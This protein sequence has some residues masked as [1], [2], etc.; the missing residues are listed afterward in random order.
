MAMPM[1]PVSSEIPLTASPDA[2]L[3]LG[4]GAGGLDGL[5]AG[6]ERTRLRL[7][8]LRGEGELALLR[9]Q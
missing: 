1:P 9:L 5:L 8:P 4:G 3:C 6:T 2:G 7:Q